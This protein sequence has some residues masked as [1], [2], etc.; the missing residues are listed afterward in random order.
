MKKHLF[1]VANVLVI[2]SLISCNQAATEENTVLPIEAPAEEEPVVEAVVENENLLVLDEGMP[3]QANIETTEGVDNIIS[4]VNSF[5]KSENIEHYHELQDT[6]QTEFQLIFKR[7]TMKGEAHNQL[8]HFLIPI[9]ESFE[10]LKSEDLTVAQEAYG[11]LKEH[12]KLYHQ[13]FIS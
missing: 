5:E 9:K 3:W 12:L 7:C 4:F 10:G 8:H 11:E 1:L 6:L 2:S 13:F